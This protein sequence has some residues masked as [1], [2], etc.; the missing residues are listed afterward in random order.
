MHEHG[1]NG[2][3]T[4]LRVGAC[5]VLPLALGCSET[6]PSPLAPS[7]AEARAVVEG[8]C[9]S[10]HSEHP[11][12]PAFPIAPSG[13]V[14]D[15]PKQMQKYAERIKVRA[16]LDRTMPLLNKTGIT[17][18]ERSVLARWVEAGARAQP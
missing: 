15:T 11:S 13:V 2:R 18:E 4:R 1:R 14:L 7:Y 16:A 6:A 17:E 12:I 5:A 10:C 9:V 8:H 3:R